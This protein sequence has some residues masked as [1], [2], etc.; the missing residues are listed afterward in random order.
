MA[1]TQREYVFTHTLLASTKA[2][3][4]FAF[5][6]DLADLI[7][8]W[9]DCSPMFVVDSMIVKA[10][11]GNAKTKAP[12]KFAVLN[13]DKT[14]CLTNEPCKQSSKWTVAYSKELPHVKIAGT[15][16]LPFHRS[17][18]PYEEDGKLAL[19]NVLAF[20][21][22][23]SFA[24][25]TEARGALEHLRSGRAARTWMCDCERC[26]LEFTV[27]CAIE[28]AGRPALR[29]QLCADGNVCVPRRK[30]PERDANV[31]RA[32]IRLLWCSQ[33]D[34]LDVVHQAA[35]LADTLERDRR[36]MPQSERY[37]HCSHQL[38]AFVAS[39]YGTLA[40]YADNYAVVR[41]HA[42]YVKVLLESPCENI[43]YVCGSLTLTTL[44]GPSLLSVRRN[45]CGIEES[46]DTIENR[47]STVAVMNAVAN[48]GCDALIR[49]VPMDF[50][51]GGGAYADRS[52]TEWSRK[53]V[54]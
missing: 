5:Q 2:Y 10:Y 26:G 18:P 11:A 21:T 7:A 16:E 44:N 49:S 47:G 54:L 27:Q 23:E 41:A 1:F 14:K 32:L 8:P 37:L 35:R 30:N 39:L 38:I 24:A 33:R 51:S 13:A 50:E 29:L 43:G 12:I 53:A 45:M 48:L 36:H 6:V 28:E 20:M 34:N 40:E 22:T 17:F 15:D 4:P 3:Q 9:G 42:P 31:H 19:S 52:I 25:A 46:G